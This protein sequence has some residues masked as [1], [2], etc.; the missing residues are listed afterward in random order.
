M[1]LVPRYSLVGCLVGLTAA[2]RKSKAAKIQAKKRV[3]V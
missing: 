3:A 2:R 1:Q